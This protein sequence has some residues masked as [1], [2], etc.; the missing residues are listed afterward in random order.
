MDVLLEHGKRVTLDELAAAKS[1]TARL[2]EQVPG[3][4]APVT[5]RGLYGDES[6]AADSPHAMT[7]DENIAAARRE[8]AEWKRK[9]PS[10][11]WR[12]VLFSVPIPR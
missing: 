11:G 2:T 1:S 6:R 3:L 8:V 5:R 12:R 4:L 9:N 10:Y 7:A